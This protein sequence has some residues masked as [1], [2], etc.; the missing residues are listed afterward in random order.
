MTENKIGAV[1]RRRC[2]AILGRIIWPSLEMQLNEMITRPDVTIVDITSGAGEFLS[3]LKQNY[4][5]NSTLVGFDPDPV[6]IAFTR[7]RLQADSE[8]SRIQLHSMSFEEMDF[9]LQAECIIG[10]C[11]LNSAGRNRA[12]VTKASQVLVQG[13]VL[14]LGMLDMSRTQSFPKSYAIDRG[15]EFIRTYQEGLQLDF[16]QQG[17]GALL[18][19]FGFG[20]VKIQRVIPRFLDGEERDLPWLLLEYLSE[21]LT[22]NRICSRTELEAVITELRHLSGRS[23]TLISAPVVY[24]LSAIKK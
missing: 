1:A 5:H 3:G 2:Q 4:N 17:L 13:G 23:E 7:D 18:A 19:G 20:H 24:Q 14:L 21:F 12:I 15:D 9:D 10:A 8:N 22:E 11:T 6:N 16:S